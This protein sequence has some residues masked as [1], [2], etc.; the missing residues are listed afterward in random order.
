[1]NGPLLFRGAVRLVPRRWRDS[2]ARDL[3]ED[4]ARSNRTGAHATAWLV[5]QAVS[6]ALRLATRSMADWWGDRPDWR[7][8]A[9]SLRLDLRLALRSV[10]H[11]PWS[12]A[13]LV[14]TLALGMSAGTAVF[15]VFNHVLFRPIPGIDASDRLAT[16]YF[17][18]AD[19]HPTYKTAP[20]E[21]L[22]ALRSARA[23]DALGASSD[24]ELPVV[25]RSGADPDFVRVEFVTDRYLDLLRV[26]PRAGRL[27]TDDDV[28]TGQSVAVISERWWRRE[29]GA[30]PSAIGQ[31]I[32]INRH[33]A[34]IVGVVADYRGWGA[35]RIGSID[36]WM[37]IDTPIGEDAVSPDRVF[38]L[39]GRLR[40]GVTT[41]IAEQQLRVPFAPYASSMRTL[42]SM[43]PLSTAPA[44]PV[45]YPGLYEIGEE[46]TRRE[47][48]QLYPFAL[49][50]SGLLLLLGCANTANLLLARTMKR[51][52]D[53]AVRSAMGAS[54]WR[55]AR[56]L[57]VEAAAIVAIA[58]AVA[59]GLAR[60]LVW[61]TQGE[62][63]FDS[64]PALDS[65]AFDWRVLAFAVVLGAITAVL[66]GLVPALTASRSTMPRA[67]A[68]SGRLT[69]SGHRLRATLVGVQ[70][71]LAVTLLAGAG[72]LVRSLQNLRGVDLGMNPDGVVSFGLNPMRLGY[73][74]DDVDALV[75]DTMD[76]LRS[77]AG[78][79]AVAFASPSPFW[80]GFI[81]ASLKA[82]PTDGALEHRVSTTVVSAD[83]FRTLQIPVRA[84]RAF[85]EA[86]FQRDGPKA[87]AGIVSESLARQLFG[88][89]PAVGRRVYLSQSARGWRVDRTI[90]IVG[91]VGDTR[92]GVDLRAPGRPALYEPAGANMSASVF[93]V[94][95]RIP[96]AQALAAA[97]TTV[98]QIDPNLPI[99]DAGALR[100]EIDRLIPEERVLAWLLACVAAIATV[101]GV[102]GVHAVIAHTVAERTRE[103]G[104]RLALGAARR[105]VLLG[106]L[107]GVVVPAIG[108]LACGL[109]LFA[110]A[111]RLLASRVYG[112]SPTDLVTL[113]SVSVL[114]VVVALAG[115]WLP[116]RR[117]T[118]VDP[119][120]ALRVE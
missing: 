35:L 39:V 54:R 88:D 14:V 96:P 74:G 118:R 63:L 28:V 33:P 77:A 72:V 42:M 15:A 95:S 56:S 65:V 41:A 26:R 6:I 78:V 50:A 114:L 18:P 68:Q 12:T 109:A 113:A 19:R 111:S 8:A 4:V 83:Y 57:L 31:S 49:G 36:I 32:T 119:A 25:A 23:F 62:Q 47:I 105:T 115:A 48:G 7:R 64:G 75:R 5:A 22:D 87:G 66:F 112:V 117:A 30:D 1:M 107:R 116:A 110:G 86:E 37:P 44:V 97:R 16:V 13:A 104:I 108:G 10:A 92:S 38:S 76:R 71:A 93:F 79:E 90:E 89:P 3:L 69:R 67:L 73:K 21:A 24:T 103:F 27:L 40:P 52:R 61:F 43:G 84:G 81:P 46:G 101:L 17:Q 91:V 53:L 51:R 106:V 120:V 85:T 20:R 82:E 99:A 34:V 100:D 2:V 102:A 98:Q 80:R 60:G 59:V 9:D 55:L 11:Q 70:L 45:V 94:R 29:L 58:A